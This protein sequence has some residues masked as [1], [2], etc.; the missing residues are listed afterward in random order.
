MYGKGMRSL[1]RRAGLV[2]CAAQLH[3]ASYLGLQAMHS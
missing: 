2:Y 3:V 1:Q